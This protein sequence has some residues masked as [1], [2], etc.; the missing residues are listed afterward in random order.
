MDNVRET[1]RGHCLVNCWRLGEDENTYTE[2]AVFWNSYVPNGIGVAIESR[3]GKLKEFFEQ[4]IEAEHPDLKRETGAAGIGGKVSYIDF[5]SE[6][7]P[8]AYPNRLLCKH[9]GFAEE[10]EY[11]LVVNSLEPERRRQ[12][13]AGANIDPPAGEYMYVDPEALIEKIY[14]APNAPSHLMNSMTSIMDG[15]SG[16]SSDSVQWSE[17]HRD[18]L[19]Y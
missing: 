13:M 16:F 14:I 5:E 9:R 8:V 15:H 17:L 10:R 11:R 18:D 19:S 12:A 6:Y 2:S 3:V 4:H 1:T 7:S